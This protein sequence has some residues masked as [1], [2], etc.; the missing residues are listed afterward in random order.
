[1]TSWRAHSLRNSTYPL[2]ELPAAMSAA[3]NLGNLA[4]VVVTR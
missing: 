2:A 4:C 1:L 3:A